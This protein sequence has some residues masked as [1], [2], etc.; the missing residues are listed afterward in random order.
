MVMKY[1]IN[2]INKNKIKKDFEDDLKSIHKILNGKDI[3]DL[4]I[5]EMNRLVFLHERSALSYRRLL[6]HLERKDANYSSFHKKSCD[7]CNFDSTHFDMN[8]PISTKILQVE[9]QNLIHIFSPFVFKKGLS[10]SFLLLFL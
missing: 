1:I 3:D 6:E 7:I 2:D 8:R 4:S 9:G 5:D 10:E